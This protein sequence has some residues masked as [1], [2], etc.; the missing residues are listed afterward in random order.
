MIHTGE[1][2]S[3]CDIDILQPAGVH[4]SCDLHPKLVSILQQE[5]YVG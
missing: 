1:N 2:V 5:I 3:V 4:I